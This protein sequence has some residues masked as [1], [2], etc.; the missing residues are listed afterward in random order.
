MKH[1][2]IVGGGFAGLKCADKL[3]ARADVRVTLID[4]NNYH[5]FQPLLYQVA[6]AQLS[7]SDIAFMIRG[8]LKEHLNVDVKMAE[9][10]S[11]DLTTRTVIRH[12]IRRWSRFLQ[13]NDD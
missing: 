6:T 2:V 7:P 8:I 1:I 12:A 3:A 4:R 5:Q 10:I 9:V 13:R 11:A